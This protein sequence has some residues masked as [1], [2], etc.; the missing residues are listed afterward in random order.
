MPRN[1][2]VAV[3]LL[4]LAAPV[5]HA[6]PRVE[7]EAIRGLGAK[8]VEAI[9][10]KDLGWITDLYAED[11]RF[12]PPGAPTAEGRDAI[13]AVWKTMLAAPG[14]TLTFEPNQIHLAGSLDHAYELGTWK[15]GDADHG[16]YVLVWKKR[17]PDWKVVADIFNSDRPSTPAPAPTQ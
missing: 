15:T 12:M 11:A 1:A 5:A 2:V 7:I 8:W 9:A 3:C 4:A 16:K 14:P 17:G 13:A 10:A 6:D